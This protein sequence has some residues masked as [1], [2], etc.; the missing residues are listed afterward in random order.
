M[1]IKKENIM[2]RIIIEICL[3]DI[4]PKLTDYITTIKI[5]CRKDGCH[6][7][8]AFVRHIWKTS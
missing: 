6:G 8:Q 2:K 7:R 3:S 4:V 1:D 5:Y